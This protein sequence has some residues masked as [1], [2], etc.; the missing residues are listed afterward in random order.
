VGASA[1]VEQDAGDEKAGENEEEVDA[2]VAGFAELI[3]KV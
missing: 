1:R 2:E 3:E